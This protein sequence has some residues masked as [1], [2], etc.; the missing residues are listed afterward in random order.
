MIGGSATL[1]ISYTCAFQYYNNNSV[2]PSVQVFNSEDELADYIE[3]RSR[4]THMPGLTVFF[5]DP[6]IMN[7]GHSLFDG[8]YPSFL[9]LVRFGRHH[10]QYNTVLSI[11]IGHSGSSLFQAVIF[12]QFGGGR[13]TKLSDLSKATLCSR[14]R[15]W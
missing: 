10:L 5:G 4:F 15:S 8:L 6:N 13:L 1:D 11:D 3:K 7:I 9:S 12:R 2:T 14:S